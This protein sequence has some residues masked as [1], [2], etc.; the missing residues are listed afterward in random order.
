MLD[1]CMRISALLI[2]TLYVATTLTAF[3]ED[4]EEVAKIFFRPPT[5]SSFKISPDGMHLSYHVVE[6][7][8]AFLRVLNLISGK[9]IQTKY[10]HTVDAQFHAWVDN[11]TVFYAML[12]ANT[13]TYSSWFALELSKKSADTFVG[14]YLPII[15]KHNLPRNE[16]AMLVETYSSKEF[17]ETKEQSYFDVSIL[18]TKK[19]SLEKVI[20]NPG[21]IRYWLVDNDGLVKIGMEFGKRGENLKG[22]YRL[23]VNEEWR[24]IEF[25]NDTIVANFLP[26]GKHIYIGH[27]NS[28]KTRGL[29]LYNL[30]EKKLIRELFH[31]D[32]Y[33][34]DSGTTF[35]LDNLTSEPIAFSVYTDKVKINYLLKDWY[36]V[37]RKIKTQFQNEVA[38]P[39]GLALNRNVYFFLSYSD[40][41]AGSLLAYYK[42]EMKVVKIM[43][44]YP[45]LSE[46]Q[47]FS[48]I[49]IKI[50]IDNGPELEGYFITPDINSSQPTIFL[51]RNRF[52]STGYAN[53]EYWEYDPTVQYFARLGYAVVLLN[54][55]GTEGYNVDNYSN[56][57]Y[58]YSIIHA[59]KDINTTARWLIDKGY[60]DERK[61]AIIGQ[62]FGSFIAIDVLKK[63]P[64]LF[65]GAIVMNGIYDLLEEKVNSG[66]SINMEPTDVWTYKYS[67]PLLTHDFLKEK[68]PISGLHSV[69][70]PIT[71]MEFVKRDPKA[72][73]FYKELKKEGKTANRIL[74]TG[75]KFDGG[76]IEGWGEVYIRIAKQIEAF[77][78]DE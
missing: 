73:A 16:N 75:T 2:T 11:D 67:D 23:N 15:Y 8:N 48:Y 68:S 25:S 77:F 64:T 65:K 54:F 70:A 50:P 34:V 29:Y 43:D 18:D 53:R 78:R 61:M 4:P 33:S 66:P 46:E 27:S 7:K 17:F 47:L 6:N 69:L 74:I 19:G 9:S 56:P 55:R 60:S 72:T 37:S 5:Y 42:D 36:D 28:R 52:N 71:I 44:S 31:S 41:N 51:V 57:N 40:V 1:E 30:E 35:A 38:W 45:H 10:P 76:T 59:A 14:T 22:I 58:S 49:P 63:Y 20:N 21:N 32:I 13:R 62:Y 3:A 24:P 12:P 39:I 26:D